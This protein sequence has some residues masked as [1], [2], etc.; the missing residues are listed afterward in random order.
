MKEPIIRAIRANE[1]HLL[2]DMLYEAIYQ[3]EGETLLPREIIRT[4][5]IDVFI[6]NF[7]KQLDDHCFVAD[8]NGKIIGAVWVRILSGKIKGYGN[9]DNE[10][11]EFA[12][13]L[14]QE[15]RNKGYGTQ[16]MKKMIEYLKEKGYKQT[17]LSV[18]KN[19][20]AVRMYQKLGFETIQEN[21]HD[22]I[23]L[24]KLR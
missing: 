13:S 7:G 21:E 12:I 18:D 2:E 15:Y 3:P 11:P 5:E 4:P 10:T 1:L 20:Y 16:M 19:N 23:M 8:L 14:F 6:N 22:Y 17:S 9:I 24:L